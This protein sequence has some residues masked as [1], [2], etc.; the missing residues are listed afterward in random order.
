[1]NA[2]I[3]SG[4]SGSRLWPVSR[5]SYPKQFCEFFDK[6]FLRDTVER[7]RPFGNIEI[8]THESMG[9]LTKSV[10]M[11]LNIGSDCILLEPY[12]KN[13]AAAIA[14]AVHQALQRGQAEEVMGVFPA[15]HLISNVKMFGDAVVWAESWAKNDRV[16][17]LGI[18][19]TYAATGYGYLAVDA[20][21]K[22]SGDKG[23]VAFNVKRFIEKPSHAK[24]EKLI[25]DKSHFW[26]AGIFFFKIQKMA[27]LLNQFMPELWRR[28]RTIEP[29]LTN[30]KYV[31]A[32]LESQS[33]DYG[34]MEKLQGDMVCIPG[35]F[36]WS[37]VGSWDEVAR[38]EEENI[39]IDSKANVFSESARDNFVYASS[40][41][42]VG[43]VGVEQLIV[44]DTPDALLVA[45]RGQ[46]QNV[47]KLV[48]SMREARLPQAAEHSFEIRPWGKFEVLADRADHKVKRLTIEPGRRMS[49]QVHQKRDEHWI[50]VSGEA[51]ITMDQ[52]SYILKAGQ[53]MFAPRGHKHRL[54]N[55]GHAPV[56]MIEVQSGQYFGEDDIIR[57]DDDYN[58][59]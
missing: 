8:V 7:L 43:L 28:I 21:S 15:D 44:V 34:I 37:D 14:L 4:G 46:T 26:N 27:D 41:K 19:P 50:V 55:L 3:L 49:Y 56:V 24:A 29:D 25:Q 11:G 31:Y 45:E 58:R 51:Q 16:V 59:A 17:T 12:A 23:L 6:S 9:M 18:P 32:N 20:Q 38:L 52:K 39:H 22:K 5:E 54:A 57:F 33:I 53:Q 1:M 36:G 13:T 30:L 48:E 47:K 40:S 10:L 35:D 42:V 2:V